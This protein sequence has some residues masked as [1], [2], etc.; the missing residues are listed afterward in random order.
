VRSWQHTRRASEQHRR[1]NKATGN[2]R[3]DLSA[4]GQ[5][6]LSTDQM[7]IWSVININDT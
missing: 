5:Q 1:Y 2:G 4:S 3:E 6:Q 7:E